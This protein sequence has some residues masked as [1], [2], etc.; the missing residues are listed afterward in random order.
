[1]PSSGQPTVTLADLTRLQEQE[2]RPT[3]LSSDEVQDYAFAVL[4]VLRG[5]PRAEKVKV[6]KRAQA[7][8]ALRRV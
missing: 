3:P 5:L 4:M 7:A 8:L 1:M 2:N 6:L